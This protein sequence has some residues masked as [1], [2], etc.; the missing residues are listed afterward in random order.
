MIELFCICI[1]AL[2]VG[3]ASC[4]LYVVWYDNVLPRQRGYHWSEKDYRWVKS[5]DDVR[6]DDN[7]GYL[8]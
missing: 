2:V 8:I 6:G 4:G 5:L 7:E 3:Y 1:G